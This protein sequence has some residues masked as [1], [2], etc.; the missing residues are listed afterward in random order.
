MLPKHFLATALM[1]NDLRQP[2]SIP[3]LHLPPPPGEGMREIMRGKAT[4]LKTTEDFSERTS[5]HG[6]GYVCYAGACPYL[7]GSRHQ[8]LNPVEGEAGGDHL[9]EHEYRDCN[10]KWISNFI[11]EELKRST[12]DSGEI[13]ETATCKW[14][15][16]R[17]NVKFDTAYRKQSSVKY[18]T[19]RVK[20]E[21]VVGPRMEQSRRWPSLRGSVKHS[22][23]LYY[24]ISV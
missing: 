13:K 10:V 5:I 7:S 22:T 6:I 15:R 11:D 16:R 20:C 12:Q 17:Q 21:T 9:E 4:L 18:G 1:V 2:Q 3:I 8:Y 24:T 23:I 19:M 14:P